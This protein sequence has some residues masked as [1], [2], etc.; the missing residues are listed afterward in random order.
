METKNKILTEMQG[1]EL[2]K[3]CQ[4]L[5]FWVV[6]ERFDKPITLLLHGLLNCCYAYETELTQCLI[7]TRKG[8]LNEV[9]KYL[10]EAAVAL[11]VHLEYTGLVI[12]F[13]QILNM[14]F[15]IE[16]QV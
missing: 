13:N 8:N 11:I 2:L 16:E 7:Q 15:D 3:F 5:S 10:K 4:N 14:Q 12:D 6:S 1:F 9:E